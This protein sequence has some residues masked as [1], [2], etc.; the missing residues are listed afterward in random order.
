[1]KFRH[2]KRGDVVYVRPGHSR[3]SAVGKLLPVTKAMASAGCFYVS[4]ECFSSESG[5]Q[6]NHNHGSGSRA[7][8]SREDYE[9]ENE[10]YRLWQ[11]FS[12]LMSRVKPPTHLSNQ[13]LLEIGVEVFGR[14]FN[15]GEK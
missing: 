10:R 9:E 1:M 14:V 15:E 8:L 3:G 5:A 7:W 6:I 2:L 12:N 4:G 11:R 13:R